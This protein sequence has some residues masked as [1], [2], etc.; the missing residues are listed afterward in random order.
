MWSRRYDDR[1]NA[2]PSS[3]A[4]PRL[5]TVSTTKG[6]SSSSSS[7]SG[8]SVP[9]APVGSPAPER[10]PFA[11]SSASSSSSSSLTPSMATSSA[12][13]PPYGADTKAFMGLSS[14]ASSTVR[15]GSAWTDTSSSNDGWGA[16]VPQGLPGPSDAMSLSD[17]K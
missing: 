4:T 8:A 6:L 2:R 16:R 15:R 3:P 11:S 10:R 5:I 17:R 1:A 13:P 9:L 14:K 12:P 7:S